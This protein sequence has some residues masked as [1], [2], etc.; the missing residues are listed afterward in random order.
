[1]VLVLIMS[2]FA[3]SD[4]GLC[5]RQGGRDLLFANT[6]NTDAILQMHTDRRSRVLLPPYCKWVIRCLVDTSLL[7]ASALLVRFLPEAGGS[8]TSLVLYPLRLRVCVRRSFTDRGDAEHRTQPPPQQKKPSP[9]PSFV[10]IVLWATL[11]L[12]RNPS[13]YIYVWTTPVLL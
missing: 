9:P 11:H 2:G 10:S 6:P 3:W 1:M 12:V 13:L 8:R 7:T 4:E 5:N